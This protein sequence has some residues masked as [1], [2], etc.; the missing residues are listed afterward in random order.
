MNESAHI[1]DELVEL[2][3][4]RFRVLGDPVRIRI[5]NHLRDAELSVGQLTE[6]IGSSQQNV[7]KHLGV[8]LDASV[9]RR[10]KVANQSLYS[11]RDD[12]VY[13]LCTEVCGSLQRQLTELGSLLEGMES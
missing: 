6:L 2:I 10:R 8:L 3:A 12:M 5:L 13:K 9:V 1:P 7:S 4:R 11:I